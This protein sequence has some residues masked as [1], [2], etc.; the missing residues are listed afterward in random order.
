M[1]SGGR[2]GR[3]NWESVTLIRIYLNITWTQQG[4]RIGYF[5]F[6]QVHSRRYFCVFSQVH[7]RRY[8]SEFSA[9]MYQLAASGRAVF[10][11]DRYGYGWNRCQRNKQK[12]QFRCLLFLLLLLHSWHCCCS[13]LLLCLCSWWF[14]TFFFDGFSLAFCFFAFMEVFSLWKKNLFFGP[15]L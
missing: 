11:H 4:L 9:I 7:S 6:S 12:V 14:L 3:T 5:D 1:T 10:E 13:S 8:F 15:K 2:E